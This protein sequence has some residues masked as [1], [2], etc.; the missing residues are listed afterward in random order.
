LGTISPPGVSDQAVGIRNAGKRAHQDGVDPTEDSR[1]GA[2]S[3]GERDHGDGGEGGIPRHHAQAIT[4]VLQKAF[5]AREGRPLAIGLPGLFDAA[6]LDRCASTGLLR[7]H[8]GAQVVFDV[9]LQVG[10]EFSLEIGLASG[11]AKESA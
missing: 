7:S 1:G 11:V 8:P 5:Q 9:H 4:E 2:D 10:F 6:K 3:D